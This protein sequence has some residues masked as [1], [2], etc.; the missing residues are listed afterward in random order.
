MRAVQIE[1][2]NERSL[3]YRRT[4]TNSAAS[5]SPVLQG[6][7]SCN[8]ALFRTHSGWAFSAC[9]YACD[10]LVRDHAHRIFYLVSDDRALAVSRR[11]YRRRCHCR[12]RRMSSSL[13]IPT[14]NCSR[15]RGGICGKCSILLIQSVYIFC[16][17][18]K[19]CRVCVCKI[20]GKIR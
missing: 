20:K 19:V 4:A 12:Y 9:P 16:V 1:S 15:P 13:L 10:D 5:M 7:S 18:F 6:V 2:K 11:V 3:V 14:R 8:S 17:I